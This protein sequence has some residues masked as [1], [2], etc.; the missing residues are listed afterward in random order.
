MRC[1]IATNRRVLL[2]IETSKA[3]GRS[4]LDGIGRYAM[5]HGRW[6]LYVEERGLADRQPA[7][8]RAW[9]GDGIIARCTTRQMLK[10][11]LSTGLPVVETHSAMIDHDLPLVYPDERAVAQLAVEHFQQRGFERF[12]F[13]TIEH[14]RWVDWRREAFEQSLKNNGF[15]CERF[16]MPRRSMS[17]ERQRD[18]LAAWVATLP[19]PMAILAANDVCGLR[20][21][22]AC[23][24]IGVHVP[25]Q[26]AV[27]GVDNDRTLCRLGDPPLSSIDLN[28]ERIGYEAAAL[29][30]RMMRR[31]T[32]SRGRPLWIEPANI[33]AR[34]STD[35]LAVDDQLVVDA[36][37][38]IRRHATRGITVHD[39]VAA[40]PTNRRSLEQRFVAALGRTPKQQIMHVRIDRAKS[41]LAETDLP[42]TI[43]STRMGYASFNYFSTVFKR[44]TGTTPRSYRLRTITRSK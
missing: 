26:V 28:V 38:W 39:L 18:R 14:E 42:V 37:R 34:Q 31:R 19:K 30:D 25:E 23:R 6:S 33:A 12:A 43:I 10:V 1:R 35:V 3:Y 15:E 11:V 20:L 4:L 29:L 8:L 24:H 44:E 27:L 7:W 41:L 32:R 2:L 40:L 16:A 22:E 36:V 13:C 21:L 9:R 5:T 17:W